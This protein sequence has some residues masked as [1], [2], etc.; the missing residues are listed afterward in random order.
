MRGQSDPDPASRH[1]PHERHEEHPEADGDHADVDAEQGHQPEEARIGLRGLDG[2]V[3]LV[4]DRRAR[5]GQD[6]DQVRGALLPGVV[7]DELLLAEAP[8][9]A[10]RVRREVHVGVGDGDLGDPD[11]VGAGIADGQLDLA[12]AQHGALDRQLLDRRAG[13]LP[14]AGAAEQR[15]A[16][17]RRGDQRQRDQGQGPE[18]Q[19][20]LAALG[21]AR[22]LHQRL[23]RDWSPMS[24]KAAGARR[25]A[26]S[27]PTRKKP[28]QPSSANSVL[29]AWNM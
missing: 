8:D 25:R 26:V 4:L 29:C 7:E 23:T 28:I 10:G 11:R 16:P 19:G 18:R 17:D 15:E 9:L 1:A 5:R 20:D 22:G 14:Q 21:A 12:G 24:Q 6:R 3:D 2:D 27:P 13:A